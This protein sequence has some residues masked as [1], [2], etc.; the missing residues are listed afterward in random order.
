MDI[1]TVA[2]GDTMVGG[3]GSLWLGWGQKGGGGLD[4]GALAR[5]CR[6]SD[7]N[8]WLVRLRGS[9]QGSK[10]GEGECWPFQ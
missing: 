5:G 6:G 7:W 8:W 9:C 2:K 4:R 3:D 10:S 1:C